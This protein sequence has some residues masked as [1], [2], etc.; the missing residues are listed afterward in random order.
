M[1]CILGK[2]RRIE[3]PGVGYLTWGKK[4][5]FPDVVGNNVRRV[6]AIGNQEIGFI[7]W[8]DFAKAGDTIASPRKSITRN[9]YHDK[10]YG[11][12][13]SHG[14]IVQHYARVAHYLCVS[15]RSLRRKPH[16]LPNS[17]LLEAEASNSQYSAASGRRTPY[18]SSPCRR[19]CGSRR[20]PL[21]RPPRRRAWRGPS[22]ATP[23]RHPPTSARLST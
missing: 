1:W 13:F 7:R 6:P 14:T 16:P 18:G 19:G 9:N 4:R 8:N 17:N 5:Q 12:D 20:R 11:S 2:W 15:L 22:P 10:H 21:R 23:R 3:F